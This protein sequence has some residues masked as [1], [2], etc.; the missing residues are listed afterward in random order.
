VLED[1]VTPLWQLW[2]EAPEMVVVPPRPVDRTLEQ[3]AVSIRLG[4]RLF[5]SDRA[6]C[7]DC[8][9]PEGYGDGPRSPLY[10]DWNRV[11]LGA[12]DAE[13]AR[14]ARLFSL[15]LQSLPARNFHDEPLHGGSRPLDI[16][17]RICI[18]IKGTP[19]PAGGP[20]PGVPGSLKPE[21]IWH[22][23]DYV[24]H[25]TGEDPPQ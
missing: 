1:G 17:W 22:L 8:H 12:D 23:V 20:S 7:T 3:W 15:P 5:T 21:E 24:R 18:G 2:R 4:R 11:K 10:D 13:T 16:Y 19:M 9:G 6:R 25:L 14:R